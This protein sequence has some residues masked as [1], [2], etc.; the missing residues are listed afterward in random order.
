MRASFEE[1]RK[2]L[3]IYGPSVTYN[4]NLVPV[5]KVPVWTSYMV[6]SKNRPLTQMR[7]SLVMSELPMSHR[8]RIE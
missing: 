7:M 5:R 3:S 4:K 8:P 6:A 1:I 2:P